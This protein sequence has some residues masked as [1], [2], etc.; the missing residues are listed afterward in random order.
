MKTLILAI[1]LS[2]F[3]LAH[4]TPPVDKG[5]NFSPNSSP[6]DGERFIIIRSGKHIYIIDTHQPM[7]KKHKVEPIKPIKP[8]PPKP[9]KSDGM[10]ASI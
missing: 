7:P 9:G 5:G 4:A 6:V 8:A 1:T 2:F 3:S 10:M